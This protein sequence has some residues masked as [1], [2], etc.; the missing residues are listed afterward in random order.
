MN[1][2]D[3]LIL[4]FLILMLIA[5]F[6]GF[7]CWLG[8]FDVV[9]GTIRSIFYNEAPSAPPNPIPEQSPI[10]GILRLSELAN[11]HGD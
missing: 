2:D 4:G 1:R 9:R 6:I 10:P 8:C 5:V 11:R 7:I 3:D